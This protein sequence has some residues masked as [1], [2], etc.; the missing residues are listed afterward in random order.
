MIKEKEFQIITKD[1]KKEVVVKAQSRILDRS[2]YFL[3]KAESKLLKETAL[4]YGDRA[5]AYYLIVCLML[6]CGLRR[7]EVV[8]LRIEQVNLVDMRIELG[9][10][11]KTRTPRVIPFNEELKRSLL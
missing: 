9:L 4:S 2:A 10:D 3:S 5:S 7:S 8:K 1:G 11:T 6:N